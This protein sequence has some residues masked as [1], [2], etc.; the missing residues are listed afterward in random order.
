[1]PMSLTENYTISNVL[2]YKTFQYNW[3]QCLHNPCLQD[4]DTVHQ[5]YTD[6]RHSLKVNLAEKS[7]RKYVLLRLL[8]MFMIFTNDD[9]RHRDLY[10]F[11][12]FGPGNRKEYSLCINLTRLEG[13]LMSGI[14][15]L[16]PSVDWICRISHPLQK[17]ICIWPLVSLS[18]L[19]CFFTDLLVWILSWGKSPR[20]EIFLDPSH[21]CSFHSS[22]SIPSHLAWH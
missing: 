19:K 1:M 20:Q 22:Y 9:S 8:K 11:N 14:A 7:T 6:S 3:F 13:F 4:S 16:Y 12:R 10:I 18:A 17:K 15:I 5:K 2:F 21:H